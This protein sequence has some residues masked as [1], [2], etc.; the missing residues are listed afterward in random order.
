M[1]SDS[2]SDAYRKVLVKRIGENLLPTAQA[3][4]L[5]WPDPSV[6]APCARHS[7]LDLSAISLQVRHWSCN[8]R[9]CCAEAG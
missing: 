7:D 5:R 4:G 1:I 2:C 6:P 3:W 8:F 9:I